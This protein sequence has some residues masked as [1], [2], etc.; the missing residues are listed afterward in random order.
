MPTYKPRKCEV[1]DAEF[2]PGHYSQIICSPE[3][4]RK[5]KRSC[6]REHHKRL[7]ELISSLKAEN[8]MLKAR[9]AELE[10]ELEAF[11]NS[12]SKL[13][14]PDKNLKFDTSG[15][16][17]CERM[18]LKMEKLPC[19]Q[20]EECW[21]NPACEHTKGLNEE[22]CR[23]SIQRKMTKGGITGDFTFKNKPKQA[24]KPYMAK[25]NPLDDGCY[26]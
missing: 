26:A 21:Q 17:F 3:C 4:Q 1:C 22:Q 24:D 19:G 16:E 7:R 25:N 9:V 2:V 14:K 12:A 5:R 11:K 8:A 10:R 20:R 13:K 18:R 23:E 6:D 15:F